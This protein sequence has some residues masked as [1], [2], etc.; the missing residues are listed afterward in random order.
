MLLVQLMILIQLLLQVAKL[1][2]KH[3]II[4]A[5]MLEQVHLLLLEVLQLKFKIAVV[6]LLE[7][8][9][10]HLTHLKLLLDHGIDNFVLLVKQ[11]DQE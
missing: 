3:L 10:D 2:P 1:L 11:V 6:P 8:V 9:L 4:H 5:L 7:F